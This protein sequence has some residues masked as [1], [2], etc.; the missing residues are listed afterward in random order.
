MINTLILIKY[1]NNTLG[2]GKIERE[3]KKTYMSMA[4]RCYGRIM[5]IDK[6][7]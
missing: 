5:Y 4:Y 3:N 2:I 6:I 7:N 1:I